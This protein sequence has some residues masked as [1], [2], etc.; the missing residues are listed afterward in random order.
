MYCSFKYSFKHT[1][2]LQCVM[3]EGICISRAVFSILFARAVRG[4]TTEALLNP[5]G[6]LV[7]ELIYPPLSSSLF[8]SLL[9]LLMSFLELEQTALCV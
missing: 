7:H 5:F 2:S 3:K 8:L 9:L 6:E 4:Q 1:R